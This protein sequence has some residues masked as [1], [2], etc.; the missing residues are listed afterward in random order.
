[1]E[2]RI[3]ALLALCKEQPFDIAKI[4]NFIYDY[5]LNANEITRV[6]LMLCDYGMFSYSDYLYL[7]H[8]E[9]MPGE[10]KTYNWEELFDVFIENGLDANLV[11][12]DD[13]INHNNILDFIR[14]LDDGDLSARILRNILSKNGTPNLQIN[15]VSFFEEFDADFIMDI[16][17]GLY[18]E[19][20]Q[21][22]KAFRFW[23]VLI[24]F[25]G[26]I[27]DG[28]L[29]VV[30]CDGY[31][32]EIFVEFENFDYSITYL[33]DDFELKIIEKKTGAVVAKV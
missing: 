32:P 12:C 31:S 14:D 6:A 23:L 26:V 10:L 19:K 21:I 8:R 30:M 22:D 11:I 9:P 24:G 29:P 17:M 28:K 15:G 7:N 2:N 16:D 27:K 25:G 13:G 18:P 5:Q 3:K 4:E 33:E 1:M 20:W